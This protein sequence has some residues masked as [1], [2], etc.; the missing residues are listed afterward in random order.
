MCCAAGDWTQVKTVLNIFVR[1]LCPE[2]RAEAE[3]VFWE[4]LSKAPESVS[5]VELCQ[6]RV[7]VALGMKKHPFFQAQ[8]TLRRFLLIFLEIKLILLEYV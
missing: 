8:Q 2:A 4:F 7:T 5:S 6:V 3:S 1:S